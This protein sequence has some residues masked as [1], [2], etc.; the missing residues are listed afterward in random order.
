MTRFNQEWGGKLLY[1]Q[2]FRSAVATERF[3]DSAV[4]GDP[5]LHPEK[6]NTAEAQV[7]YTS[8][9]YTAAITYFHSEIEDVIN[10]VDIGGG[11]FQFVNEG[12][13]SS[14]GVEL[15]GNM[16]ISKAMG[17]IASLT[18]Q[19]NEDANGLDASLA[20]NLMAKLGISYTAAGYSLGVF[21][22]YFDEPTPVREVNPLVSEVNPQPAAYHLVTAEFSMDIRK[23]FARP[24]LPDMTFSIY[25]DNLLDEDIYYPEINRK[26]INSIPVYSG[27]AVYATLAVKF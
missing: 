17:L 2:A 18:Y 24:A 13:V 6:I 7:F 11:T 25:A 19:Q 9:N 14:K 1:S 8:R 23:V 5:S 10:R 26:N 15:E 3:L 20:P 12:T 4:I 21:D 22:T 16:K 27:R